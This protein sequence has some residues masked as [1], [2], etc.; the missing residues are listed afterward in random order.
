MT[1][2][3]LIIFSLFGLIIGSFLNVVI[4]RFNTHRSMGGRSACMSCQSKLHWY[5][6]VPVFSFVAL[7]G[8]CRSCKTKISTQYPLVELSTGLI[9]GMLFWKF[10]DMFFLDPIMFSFTYA[11][12][13][14]LFAILLI[15]TVYDI[16]HK[17][18]PDMLAF[19]FG[20][21]AFVGMFFF[22]TSSFGSISI[23]YPHIPSLMDFLSSFAVALP[24]AL[25][26]FVSRGAWMG[27]GDAKLAVGLGFMLC[28]G[29][30]LSATVI[31]FWSG[32]IV[33]LLLIAMKRVGG[34]KSE[35]PFGPFLVLGAFLA[36]V[37]ELNLFQIF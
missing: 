24:F 28:L 32:A 18:I 13:A 8:R 12:Y 23:F 4:Y 2:M 1:S 15:I 36:F 14:T 10:Q 17:I 20:A 21:F 22:D 29:K 33:G 26:W 3:L 31:S 9:F 7:Q 37:F 6:L 5:D 19:V 34:M 35:I 30:L 25:L 27:L 11:Y 16:K